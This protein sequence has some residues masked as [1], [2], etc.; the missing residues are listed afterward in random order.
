MN[1]VNRG[2]VPSRKILFMREKT[3]KY[4]YIVSSMI[5]FFY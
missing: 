3:H 4:E 5:F 1:V 2:I